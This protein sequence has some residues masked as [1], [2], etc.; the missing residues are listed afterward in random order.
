MTHDTL[1][2]KSIGQRIRAAREQHHWT[3]EELAEKVELSVNTMA[4]I[5]L[6][7]N[8]TRLENFV[9]LCRLLEVNAD[10]ILFGDAPPAAQR[11]ME[12]LRDRDEETLRVVEKTV[13]AL[14]QALD[15]RC[16]E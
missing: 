9:R 14:L 6:G 7:R 11:V 4:E 16:P 10:Y 12:L 8:G 1:D 3:R 15:E 2:K 5:E 13:A